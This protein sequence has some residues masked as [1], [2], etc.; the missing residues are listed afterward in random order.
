MRQ[1]CDAALG[2]GISPAIRNR[3]PAAAEV[4]APACLAKCGP[5]AERNACFSSLSLPRPFAEPF[6]P[7][8]R[9]TVM[10]IVPECAGGGGGRRSL[11]V[12]ISSR[13]NPAVA[14][15]SARLELT[16]HFSQ[17]IR[18]SSGET[19]APT[20]SGRRAGEQDSPAGCYFPNICVP[21]V[22]HNSR[23]RLD[24]SSTDLVKGSR[25]S[26]WPWSL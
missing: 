3:I 25:W 5:R 13:E 20:V 9:G 2:Q 14:R 18:S 11:S 12:E 21:S 8:H 26:N 7:T 15:I 23:E 16:S 1:R 24:E 19:A 4:D 10:R 6:L 17:P 22:A